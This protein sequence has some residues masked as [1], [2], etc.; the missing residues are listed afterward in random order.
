MRAISLRRP[1]ARV[2]AQAA[3]VML[4][5]LTSLVVPSS[6][7]SSAAAASGCGT[8]RIGDTGACVVTL[9]KR[10]HRLHYDL[11]RDYG[12]FGTQTFHAV[13]AFQKANGLTRN[14]IVGPVTWR[15]LLQHPSPPQLRYVDSGSAI[16]VNLSR[17]IALRA[18]AGRVIRIYDVSTGRPGWSTPASGG[19]PFGIWRKALWGSTM[20]TDTEHFVQYY[21]AGTTLAMHEYGYVPP[22]PASH[23]CI[24]LPSGS[25]ARLYAHTFVGERVYTYY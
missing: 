10:L 22:F 1:G 15:H 21:K 9:Q 11:A 5:V 18:S 14:G 3:A 2:R 24:R 16:E 12:T 4:G 25:A 6:T 23:G 20:G 7:A 17:Q 13:V 19:N 8:L